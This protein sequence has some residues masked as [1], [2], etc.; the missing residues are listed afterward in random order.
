VANS[1]FPRVRLADPDD[2]QAIRVCLSEAFAP[3]ERSYTSAA[4]DDTVPTVGGLRDRMEAVIIL[5]AEDRLGRIVGTLSYQVGRTGEG[6]LRGMAVLPEALGSTTASRLLQAAERA[7]LR[8]GCSRVTLD[9][10]RPLQRAVA[11]YQRHGYRPTGRIR[12]FYG[13]PLF[14]HSKEIGPGI[15]KQDSGG[16]KQ[17]RG[18]SR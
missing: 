8:A 6:H 15:G 7:L 17:Q 9:T 14:E 18:G 5:V 11:F 4:F 1:S 12:D 10:T 13:M 2:I 3:Y 16:R